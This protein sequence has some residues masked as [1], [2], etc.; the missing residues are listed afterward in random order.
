[1]SPG[2]AFFAS[3]A[4]VFL[5]MIV[6]AYLWYHY[7]G[8]KRFSFASGEEG[9][10]SAGKQPVSRMRFKDC[11]FSFSDPSG[12]RHS[13]DVTP[14]LNGMAVAY[15]GTGVTSFTLGGVAHRPLNAFT[16]TLRDVNDRRTVPTKEQ[17]ARWATCPA[18]LDGF[19]RII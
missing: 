10:F 7:S 9:V 2:E 4:I 17:A 16:F 11:V 18:R 13:K 14:T 12:N 5:L 6:A 15:A 8:W 19:L 1:M 3:C